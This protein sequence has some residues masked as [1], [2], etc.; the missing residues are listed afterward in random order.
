MTQPNLPA[1]AVVRRPVSA[2][3]LLCLLAFVA[4]VCIAGATRIAWLLAA[5]RVEMLSST[6]ALVSIGSRLLLGAAAMF[7]AVGVHRRKSWGR[8][9]GLLAI[10]V[11]GA[12]S[13]LR[14]DLEPYP[15]EA[16]EAGAWLAKLVLLPVLYLWWAY[17]YAFSTKAATYFVR[18]TKHAA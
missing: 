10:L 1:T 16:Q 5:Q 3:L 17:A 13:V 15:N 12:W 8:W 6:P 7:I 2:W 4:V 11:F 9:I 18:E 14:P